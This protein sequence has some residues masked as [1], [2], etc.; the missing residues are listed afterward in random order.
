MATKASRAL[1]RHLSI[2]KQAPLEGEVGGRALFLLIKLWSKNEQ[3][4][5]SHAGHGAATAMNGLS[6]DCSTVFVRKR[7]ARA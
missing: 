3:P 4:G 5:A 6:T 7:K 2:G 1:P